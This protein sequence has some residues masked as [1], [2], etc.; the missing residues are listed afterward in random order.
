MPCF[1]F[2]HQKSR[3]FRSILMVNIH[4]RERLQ[5]ANAIRNKISIK[6]EKLHISIR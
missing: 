2:S 3:D 1:L 6:T 4:L 5:Y